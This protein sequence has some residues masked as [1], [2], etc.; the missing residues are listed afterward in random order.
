MAELG[1]WDS[2]SYSLEFGLLNKFV[3]AVSAQAH[4]R[5]RRCEPVSRRHSMGIRFTFLHI[6]LLSSRLS[7]PASLLEPIPNLEY[8]SYC[9]RADFFA[10]SVP[11]NFRRRFKH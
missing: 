11:P 2:W 6:D 8:W 7:L 10:A 9:D 5:L 1:L 4:G 3:A